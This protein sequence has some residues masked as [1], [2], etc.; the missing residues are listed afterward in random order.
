MSRKMPDIK[1]L[2]GLWKYV[3]PAALLL[4]V[5]YFFYRWIGVYTSGILGN[6][7]D[8][9][10]SGG[11]LDRAFPLQLA[12]AFVCALALMP[13]IDLL[14]NILLFRKGLKYEA[15]VTEAV[16]SKDAE[17]IGRLQSNEWMARIFDD[18]LAWRQMALVTPMRILA[19]GTVFVIAWV[20][21]ISLDIFLAFLFLAGGIL[22]FV[23][24]R[25]FEKASIRIQEE[26]RAYED[27]K[28]MYQR[29]FFSP[30]R[31]G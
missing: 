24:Q 19:D 20:Q 15:E 23:I 30:I 16:F 22:A 3:W 26:S 7:A 11:E 12:L 31:F 10:L 28:T 14:T 13:G 29:N 18:P 5:S 1:I 27:K 2:A 21:L 6:I 25:L 8:G 4:Y 17:Q 9:V